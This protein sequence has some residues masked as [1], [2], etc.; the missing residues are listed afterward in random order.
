MTDVCYFRVSPCR[1]YARPTCVCIYVAQLS[2]NRFIVA[3]CRTDGSLLER[4][5]APTFE[6]RQVGDLS[7]L[8]SDESLFYC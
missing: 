4:G 6:L 3:A 2:P 8:Q 1:V 5:I 7:Q